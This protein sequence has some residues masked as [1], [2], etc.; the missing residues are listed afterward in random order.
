MLDANMKIEIL[1]GLVIIAAF[2]LG[3]IVGAIKSAKICFKY[4]HVWDDP[5][6]PKPNLMV[7]ASN[8][9]L[10]HGEDTKQ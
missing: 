10:K 8:T 4:R 1:I 7:I 3:F 2:L 6:A 5:K 9:E